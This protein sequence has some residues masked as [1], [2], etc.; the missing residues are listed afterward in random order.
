M[1]H[2]EKTLESREIYKGRVFRV[3]LDRVELE[4]GKMTSREIVRHHGGACI[5]ALTEGQEVYLVR[6]F[7]YAFGRTLW[8][9]PA[10]KLEE[11][12]DPLE[13]AKREL[14]EEC[15]VTA[16]TWRDLHPILP[17]VGYDDETIYLFLA[18]DLQP[19]EM[20]LDEGEFLTPEKLPLA[21]A[22]EMVESGE[23]QDGKTVAAL[24]KLRVAQLEGKI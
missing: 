22:L 19:A 21:K 6:Q 14:R 12:E 16:R 9:L 18:T 2:F 15:G 3:Y 20:Q 24:L 5:L 13:A 11:G 17:T 1:E 4:N 8:E 10:G 23:I 7:R